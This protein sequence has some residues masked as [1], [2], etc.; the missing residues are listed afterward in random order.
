[1]LPRHRLVPL[2]RAR[3]RGA[4]LN[5]SPPLRVALSHSRTNPPVVHLRV[6]RRVSRSLRQWY[7][8]STHCRQIFAGP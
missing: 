4:L 7:K 8:L 3:K 1:M 6:P 5:S 2:A